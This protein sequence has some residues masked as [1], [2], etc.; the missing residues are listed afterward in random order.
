MTFL[1]NRLPFHATIQRIT[2]CIRLFFHAVPTGRAHKEESFLIPYCPA[3]AAFPADALSQNLR[4]LNRLFPALLNQAAADISSFPHG[5]GMVDFLIAAVSLWL[6][7]LRDINAQG[8]LRPYESVQLMVDIAV[9]LLLEPPLP[10]SIFLPSGIVCPV[11]IIAPCLLPYPIGIFRL[12]LA[13]LLAITMPFVCRK[14]GIQPQRHSNPVAVVP[15]SADC[16]LHRG[17]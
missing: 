15:M 4:Y 16:H 12:V 11:A 17:I 6:G 9:H 14:H 8:F 10:G 7:Q 3:A 1:T 13:Q 2:R 5:H